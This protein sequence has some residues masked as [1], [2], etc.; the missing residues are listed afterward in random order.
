MIRAE[1][2]ALGVSSRQCG[3]VKSGGLGV[4]QI[5]WSQLHLLASHCELRM[6]LNLS[7]P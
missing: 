6:L 2:W 7:G 4:S 5:W 1:G 3:L